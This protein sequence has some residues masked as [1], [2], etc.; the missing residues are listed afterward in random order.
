MKHWLKSVLYVPKHAKTNDENIRHLL[1]PSFLGILLCMVCLAGTTWAWFTASISTP[2]QSIATANYKIN[3]TVNGETVTAQKQLIA[4][5]EYEIKLVAG[6]T[7]NEF[8]GY[9]IVK[10][11]ENPLYSEQLLPGNT[12]SFKFTPS[13]TADYTFDAVWGVY[14][15]K[16]DITNG[17]I[18]GQGTVTHHVLTNSELQQNSVGQQDVYIVQEGD[19]LWKIA[20]EH[21]TTVEKLAMYNAIDQNAIL[22]IEQ[23]I[24]IPPQNYEIPSDLS[25]T[26]VIPEKIVESTENKKLAETSSASK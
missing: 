6:G 10:G 2:P 18:I 19:S 25:S 16:P 14:S 9:C 4:N 23:K 7:A 24:K 20:Q 26:D 1:V 8:G 21:N 3:V 15:Q 22:Q 17:C 11:G 5:R 12:L 13:V